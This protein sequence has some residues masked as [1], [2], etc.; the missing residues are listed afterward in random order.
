MRKAPF[1]LTGWLC[2]ADLAVGLVI[3]KDDPKTDLEYQEDEKAKTYMETWRSKGWDT[4]KKSCTVSNLP[5]TTDAMVLKLCGKDAD[6]SSCLCNIAKAHSC[7]VGCRKLKSRC[8]PECGHGKCHDGSGGNGGH[9]LN[10]PGKTG[11][12][13]KFCSPAAPHRYCGTGQWYETGLYVDCSG[14]DPSFAKRAKTA[15][16]KKVIWTTCMADCYPTPTCADMCANA[17]PDCYAKCVDR[18]R[19]VV[20]P[21]WEMF[22]GSLATVPLIP[23]KETE[24]KAPEEEPVK[25]VAPKEEPV[26]EEAKP[27]SEEPVKKEEPVKDEAGHEGEEEYE[28]EEWEDPWADDE[29]DYEEDYDEYEGDLNFLRSKSN[30]TGLKN[31]RGRRVRHSKRFP[32]HRNLLNK[33]QSLGLT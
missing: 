27:K 6:Q 14:C 25:K 8:P 31:L 18:Y 11:K 30:K 22:K 17:S 10:P 1:A 26:K 15:A 32:E 23:P 7:H 2:F 12:C 19:G 9:A 33:A 24:T 20:A 5:A 4:S 29:D 13:Y 16:Q 3:Q 28:E 21:Y